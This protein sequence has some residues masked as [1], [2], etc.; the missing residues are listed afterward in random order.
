MSSLVIRK[1]TSNKFT[2]VY[3]DSFMET[4]WNLKNFEETYNKI[5]K[6][7]DRDLL[8]V[9]MLCSLKPTERSQFVKAYRSASNI[10]YRCVKTRREWDYD[11]YTGEW[12]ELRV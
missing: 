7:K 1:V 5:I 12:R 9:A 2:A 3:G 6:V 10:V 4:E 8:H 11:R